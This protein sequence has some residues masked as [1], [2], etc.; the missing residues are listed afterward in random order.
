M[1]ANKP[2]AAPTNTTAAAP[3]DTEDHRKGG[4]DALWAL[5]EWADKQSATYLNLQRGAARDYEADPS[6]TALLTIILQHGQAHRTYASVA[7]EA[8]TRATEVMHPPAKLTTENGG[9]Q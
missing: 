6:K 8:R 1:P 4:Y 3:T 7:R 2:A 5:A 9:K